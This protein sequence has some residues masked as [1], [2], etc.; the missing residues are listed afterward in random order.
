MLMNCQYTLNSRHIIN[1]PT[2]QDP[3]RSGAPKQ[4]GNRECV[5]FGYRSIRVVIRWAS[6]CQDVHIS[7]YTVFALTVPLFSTNEPC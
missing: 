4:E 2:I 7:Y 1:R 3:E 6:Q 5:L